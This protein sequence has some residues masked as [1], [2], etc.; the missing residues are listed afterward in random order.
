MLGV[1]KSIG[2]GFDERFTFN[3]GNG[4][5]IGD[6]GTELLIFIEECLFDFGGEDPLDDGKLCGNGS[7]KIFLSA[8]SKFRLFSVMISRML[9]TIICKRGS[10]L[11]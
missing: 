3:C 7:G 8:A 10:T 1:G 2:L 4:E 11:A 6:G 5:S 9:S